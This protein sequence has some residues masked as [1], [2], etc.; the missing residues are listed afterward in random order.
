MGRH[1]SALTG[2]SILDG[3]SPLKSEAGHKPV[4]ASPISLD[5]KF[6]VS[7]KG[8]GAREHWRAAEVQPLV[9][10]TSPV[11]SPTAPF[12]SHPLPGGTMLF[13]SPAPLILVVHSPGAVF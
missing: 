8:C 6:Q 10:D 3:L 4:L 5:S 2:C 13:G 11:R 7:R 12:L 9:C 1:S